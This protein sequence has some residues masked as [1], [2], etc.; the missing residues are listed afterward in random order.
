M[1]AGEQTELREH[2]GIHLLGFID[3]QDGAVQRGLDLGLPSF[4]KSFGPVPTVVRVEG[5]S[6]EITQFSIEIEEGGLGAREDSDHDV[7]HSAESIGED[8]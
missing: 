1:G 5:D 2:R 4:P 7:L 8:A 3:D 6:E